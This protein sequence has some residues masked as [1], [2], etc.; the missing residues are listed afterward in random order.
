[1]KNI[2]SS[3]ILAL[4]LFVL[5]QT[6]NYFT[7]GTFFNKSKKIY[8]QGIEAENNN[9]YELA[10]S[11]YKKALESGYDKASDKIDDLQRRILFAKK[12]EESER[13]FQDGLRFENSNSYVKAALSY[14]KAADQ[15]NITAMNR[16]DHIINNLP[17]YMSNIAESN[18]KICEDF[19]KLLP[20]LNQIGSSNL[21]SYKGYYKGYKVNIAYG[22]E[23]KL[24]CFF[25]ME[26]RNIS[27]NKCFNFFEGF[28]EIIYQIANT[29]GEN[30]ETED[31]EKFSKKMYPYDRYS[32]DRKYTYL[33]RFGGK[34]LYL[35]TND[36]KILTECYLGQRCTEY[37]KNGNETE[38]ITEPMCRFQIDSRSACK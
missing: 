34:K 2:D 20:S 1:M 8:Q 5:I 27:S 7:D 33:V 23:T 12:N 11:L 37:Y 36:Y 19:I 32:S 22:P 18:N 29:Y 14:K 31:L 9:N 17:L 15:G 28:S 13:F 3:F 38:D 30:T 25:Q 16:L 10:L 26:R 24:L 21:I 4:I 6:V 35:K